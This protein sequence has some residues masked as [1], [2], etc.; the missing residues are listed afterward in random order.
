MAI[1]SIL[2]PF[3]IFCDP[4]KYF[5]VIWYILPYFGMFFPEKNLATL[6]GNWKCETEAA[7]MN[8]RNKT[9]VD[10]FHARAM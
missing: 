3:S 6:A 5:V 10:I 2:R 9:S 7:E 8:Y 4:L 1:C